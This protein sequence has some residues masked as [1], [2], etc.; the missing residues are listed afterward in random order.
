MGERDA[1]AEP[2]GYA[3]RLHG[4]AAESIVDGPGLRY[5]VFAQ[6]C[7]HRCPGCHN[8]QS[9]DP[10][11]GYTADA[12]AVLAAFK[13]NPL[14]S[15]ITLSGGEPFAQAEVLAWLAEEVKKLG[16]DV[17]VYSGYTLAQLQS[18]AQRGQ[19]RAVARLLAVTDVLIDGPYQEAERDLE[20]LWRGS[21]NQQVWRL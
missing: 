13:A 12:R 2:Q 20:L 19:G 7:P 3:L 16:K 9:H 21:A 18:M 11:G 15:G 14:L 10:D 6:G 1:R 5:A 8:P 4:V 17:V